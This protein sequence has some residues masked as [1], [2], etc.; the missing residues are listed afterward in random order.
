MQY[1]HFQNWYSPTSEKVQVQRRQT[2]WLK[3]TDLTELKK[4]TIITYSNCSNYSF[5]F[6]S[7]FCCCLFCLKKIH[8]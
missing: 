5:F 2:N 7:K 8:S 1:H 3:Y 6:K 4:I